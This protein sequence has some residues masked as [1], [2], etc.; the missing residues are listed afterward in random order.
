MSTPGQSTLPARVRAAARRVAADQKDDGSFGLAYDGPFTVADT[1]MSATLLYIAGATA[2]PLDTSDGLSEGDRTLD[3]AL[4]RALT[5]ICERIERLSGV[6]ATEPQ[7][8][9]FALLGIA[10]TTRAWMPAAMVDPRWAAAIAR[11]LRG[12]ERLQLPG[13]GLPGLGLPGCLSPV[14]TAR[15]L[16]ALSDAARHGWLGDRA[17]ADHLGD[18]PLE[19]ARHVIDRSATALVAACEDGAW[20]FNMRE[21]ET[22]SVTATGLAVLALAA[23]R[24]THLVDRHAHRTV[25]RAG[26][27]WLADRPAQWYAAERHPGVQDGA[28]HWSHLPYHYALLAC[29]AVRERARD[30][31][32]RNARAALADSY[33]SDGE[34]GPGWPDLTQPGREVTRSATIAAVAVLTAGEGSFSE[35][36]ALLDVPALTLADVRIV[37]DGDIVRIVA[38]GG[39]VRGIIPT[40][41]QLERSLLALL[42]TA[43]GRVAITELQRALP[44]RDGSERPA[45]TLGTDVSRLRARLAEGLVAAGVTLP[46][47][48]RRLIQARRD[49]YA[50]PELRIERRR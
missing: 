7:R 37:L 23:L 2:R 12:I 27:A 50:W 45:K 39:E 40:P 13:G 4:R 44:L 31:R 14:I 36:K 49:H 32:V 42:A 6:A 41:S 46:G 34:G 28:E 38:D 9:N 16:L 48:P 20:R 17:V 21:G 18:E 26:A 47:P 33:R 24:R 10:R 1:A 29:A 43:T 11:C 30:E 8:F 15:S 19:L 22:A 3:R 25:I 5:A 35:P